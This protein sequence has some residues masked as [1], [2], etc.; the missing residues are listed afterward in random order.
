MILNKLLY[1]QLRNFA[2]EDVDALNG[3]EENVKAHAFARLEQWLKGDFQQYF[4]NKMPDNSPMNTVL[5]TIKVHGDTLYDIFRGTKAAP[6]QSKERQKQLEQL[7][8][9][10][11]GKEVG[12]HISENECFQ[13]YWR[14]F[15]RHGRKRTVAVRKE[16]RGED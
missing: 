7:I 12:F 11:L 14:W 3:L 2:Y 10:T 16:L 4:R 5:H 15:F 9:E 1:E 13:E 6:Y 8:P